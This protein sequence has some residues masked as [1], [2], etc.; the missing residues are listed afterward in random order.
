[1]NNE[2]RKPT[3]ADRVLEYLQK[4]GSITQ[5]DA[6]M[7]L[8]IMRLASRISEIQSERGIAIASDYQTVVNRFGE[9]ASI[10]RYKFAEVQ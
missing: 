7:E 1:M 6:L 2:N 4:Y 8:G 9:K 3:Q 5:W 10:K